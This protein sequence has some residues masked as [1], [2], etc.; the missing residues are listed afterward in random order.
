[1]NNIISFCTITILFI[2]Y[3]SIRVSLVLHKY[4]NGIFICCHRSPSIC[5]VHRHG[6]LTGVSNRWL[7]KISLPFQRPVELSVRL[8]GFVRLKGWETEWYFMKLW[9]AHLYSHNDDV[10]K[11]C[12]WPCLVYIATLG[13][14]SLVFPDSTNLTFVSSRRHRRWD[15]G[16]YG[17]Y[18]RFF[19]ASSFAYNFVRK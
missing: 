10:I 15:G 2:N 7:V 6:W 5:I 13:V 4:I 8:K 17:F 18:L 19:L 12:T 1:M 16:S 3:F 14:P 11:H 9:Q